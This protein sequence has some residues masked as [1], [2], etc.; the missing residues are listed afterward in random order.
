ME[1]IAEMMGKTFGIGI[2]VYGFD[3][4]EGLPPPE[5]YKDLPF[6]WQSNFYKMDVKKLQEKLKGATLLLGDAGDTTSKL[7]SQTNVAPFGFLSFDMDYYSSTKRS[8]SIFGGPAGTRLPRVFCYFDDIASEIG[9][10]NEYIGE[11]CAIREFNEEQPHQ[12]IAH[13]NDLEWMLPHKD[14][15]QRKIFVMHDFAH[16]LYETYICAPNEAGK[17]AL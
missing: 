5:S 10:Y 9:C 4:G 14:A 12:K 15:W 3:T 6:Y 1:R 11:L 13:L 7:L 8:F 16:P 2:H 17:C